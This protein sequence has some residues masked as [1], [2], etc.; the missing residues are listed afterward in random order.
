M[1]SEIEPQLRSSL[2][3]GHIAFASLASLRAL[4][5]QARGD[6]Q[7]ALELTHQSVATAEAAMKEGRESGGYLPMFLIR[8]SHI[9]LQLGQKEEAATDATRALKMSLEAIQPGTFSANIG[10]AYLVLGRALQAQD[11]GEEARAAFRS[12]VEQMQSTLGFDHAETREARQLAAL[13]IKLR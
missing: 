7:M 2:P 9:H 4:V 8:R 1:L 5:A 3:P 13:E 10:R 11:K 12:A 6:T